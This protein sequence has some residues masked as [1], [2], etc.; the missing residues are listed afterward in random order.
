MPDGWDS[1][2]TLATIDRIPN[3]SDVC[4]ALRS[5][6]HSVR[7]GLVGVGGFHGIRAI[8]LEEGDGRAAGGS[9]DTGRSFG[10]SHRTELQKPG[11]ALQRGDGFVEVVCCVDRKHGPWGS[12]V[13]DKQE[14]AGTKVDCSNVGAEVPEPPM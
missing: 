11:T 14:G 4:R 13:G 12:V 9:E 3:F 1:I 10:R 6:D 8:H 5:L 7:V 2:V